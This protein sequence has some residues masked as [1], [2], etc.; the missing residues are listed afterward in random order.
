MFVSCSEISVSV[1]FK[2]VGHIGTIRAFYLPG[3]TFQC[4]E[5]EKIAGL[6]SWVNIFSKS[7][8][9]LLEN[10]QCSIHAQMVFSTS[11]NGMQPNLIIEIQKSY[12]Q[13]LSL[14]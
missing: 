3:G 12:S 6:L 13:N 7:A 11:Q 14:K 2:Y 9:P 1:I 4:C 8:P 5:T 10:A